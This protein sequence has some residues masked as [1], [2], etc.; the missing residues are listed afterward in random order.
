[1][2]ALKARR[3]APLALAA[4]MI[5]GGAAE[6]QRIDDLARAGRVEAAAC[7]HRLAQMRDMAQYYDRMAADLP[8]MERQAAELQAQLGAL[9]PQ[10]REASSRLASLG[11]EQE[12]L[13]DELPKAQKDCREAWFPSMSGACSRA[14]QIARRLDGEVNPELGR[15]RAALPPLESER[16][17]V[18]ATLSVLQMN[19][20]SR[21]N[22]VARQTRPT[23]EQIAEQDGRCRTLEVSMAREPAPAALEISASAPEA[24]A[25]EEI[26]LRA[27]IASPVP[28]ARY[29][30]VWSLNGKVFGDNGDS[31]KTAIPG[32]GINTVRVVAWLW[33]GGQWVRAAEASRAIAGKA[34]VQQSVTISGPSTMAIRDGAA[35][36]TFEA[37]ITPEVSG[38]TCGFTWGAVGDP[39]GPVTFSNQSASQSLTVTAPGRYTVLVHAWKLVNGQWVLV[40]KAAHP[41]MVQ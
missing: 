33:T 28:G 6:A 39:Q 14:E 36:G 9:I 35:R 5:S 31:V 7:R 15:L 21:R 40:G 24:L 18:E 30:F 17:R 23:E 13:S 41:F 34:R 11:R 32:E 12:A 37:R 19:L 26:T 8:G 29:G 25:G 20:Q 10:I 4:L 22:Y 16:Q 27:R 2:I 1:M 38:Q 3:L